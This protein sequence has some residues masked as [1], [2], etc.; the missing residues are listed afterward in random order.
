MGISL[1]TNE[2]IEE[3]GELEKIEPS[4]LYF[5]DSYGALEP[6]RTEQI[7]ELFKQFSSPV[8]VHHA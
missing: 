8:G 1:L 6:I 3:F 5:A 4:A 7:V 2:E